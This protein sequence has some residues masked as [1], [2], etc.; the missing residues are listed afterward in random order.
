MLSRAH[1]GTVEWDEG[2]IADASQ[3]ASFALDGFVSVVIGR[4][5]RLVQ[6][7]D[8]DFDAALSLRMLIGSN[9]A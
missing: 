5:E 2:R 7:I 4:N 1:Q 6:A 8:V 3:V 9:D